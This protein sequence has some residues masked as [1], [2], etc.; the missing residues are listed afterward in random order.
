MTEESQFSVR[1]WF[2]HTRLAIVARAAF[3]LLLLANVGYLAASMLRTEP[4]PEPPPT[5]PD[6]VAR[7]VLLSEQQG[8]LEPQNARLDTVPN[9]SCYS[10]GPFATP[11]N[12]EQALDVVAPLADTTRERRLMT[13]EQEGFVVAMDPAPTREAAL[14]RA[15]EL[16]EAGIRDYYVITAGAEE[17]GI[18]LGLYRDEV[19]AQRRQR[20]LAQSGFDARLLARRQSFPEYWLDYAELPDRPAQWES[21]LNEFPNLTRSSIPCF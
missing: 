8:V 19:N 4:A 21:L 3:L 7:L 9:A 20:E 13:A 15:R 10:L 2:G 17:N 14:Q 12:M 18:S 5:V 16:N 6:G 1:Q 11:E